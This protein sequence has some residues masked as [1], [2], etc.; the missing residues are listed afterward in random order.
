MRETIP[1]TF[2][3]K[4]QLTVRTIIDNSQWRRNQTHIKLCLLV[5]RFDSTVYTEER[6]RRP[7]TVEEVKTNLAIDFSP[8]TRYMITTSDVIMYVLS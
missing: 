2:L 5:I 8:C 6:V 4:A 3:V 7:G 1:S